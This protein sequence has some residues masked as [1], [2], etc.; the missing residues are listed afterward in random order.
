[1]ATL[2]NKTYKFY[3]DIF[4]IDDTKIMFYGNIDFDYT[5]KLPLLGIGGHSSVYKLRIGGKFYAL[6][7]F[8][9]FKEEILENYEEKSKLHIDSYISPIK[10]MYLNEK[11]SGYLMECCNGKDLG[12]RKLNISVEDFAKDS[13]KLFGD[14]H[15]LSLNKYVIFD[16]YITN[17]MHDNG[18]KMIDMD[19]YPHK[20][21]WSIDQ[22][23][24][25]NKERLNQAL[26]DVFIKNTGIASFIFEN[27]D[28]QKLIN[29]CKDG[30]VSFEELFN[31]VCTVAYNNTEEQITEISDIGK[32][33]KKTKLVK[34]SNISTD[35]YY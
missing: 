23:E 31:K 5:H 19:D 35:D 24:L 18:F 29:A 17:I 25:K 11:F 30:K 12:R 7:I 27:V 28:L 14:T 9:N 32:V 15:E 22:V 2:E 34:F 21:D 26:L 3:D 20:K 16:S 1:M 13:I 8:N 6:K 33:L 10:L 4:K